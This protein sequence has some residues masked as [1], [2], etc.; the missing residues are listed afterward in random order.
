[1]R[2]RAAVIASLIV[3]LLL[4]GAGS[5]YAFDHGRRDTIAKGVTVNGVPVGGLTVE[6]ARAKVRATLLEPLDR[7]V[8]VR[9]RDKRF[10]LTP[11]RAGIGLD[12]D[13]SV[14]RA[15]AASRE[16]GVLA[17]TWRDLTGGRLHE[18]VRADVAWDRAS[19]RRLVARVRRAVDRPARDAELD[20]EGGAVDPTPSRDGVAVRASWLRR[21]VGRTLLSTGERDT[22]RVRTEVVKPKVTTAALAEKYPAVLVVDRGAFRITLYKDLKPFKS[23]GIAVGQAGLETPAG[24]YS[25]Q[26]KAVNPAWHVPNS[27]WAGDLAGKVISGD[28]PSNPIKAR[29]LG[30][31][32]GVG[33]HG[34]GDPGS[35]GSAASHGC[36][37]MRIPEVIELYDQVPVGAPIYIS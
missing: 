10:T 1:M 36:I 12:V 21:T 16:D 30:I 35:I 31:Y 2:R 33:V 18:D 3:A 28:D 8:V 19:V 17:R 25:I 15:V 20:L 26:N 32:D 23:Y 4:V 5:V 9:H 34:T 37:R 27:D 13:G 6:Q 7:P 22:I 11:E 14:D 24:L 29:W